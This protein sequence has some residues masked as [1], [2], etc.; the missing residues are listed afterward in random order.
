MRSRWRSGLSLPKAEFIADPKS[1]PNSYLR[2]LRYHHAGCWHGQVEVPPRDPL[3]QGFL[4]DTRAK[5][6]Q[7]VGVP[8]NKKIP[9]LNPR[10]L[11]CS[12]LLWQNM[13]WQHHR[14]ALANPSH[15]IIYIFD[16]D[17]CPDESSASY[18]VRRD[19]PSTYLLPRSQ[20]LIY[21]SCTLVKQSQNPDMFYLTTRLHCRRHGLRMPDSSAFLQG[22][23]KVESMPIPVEHL[24]PPYR[25][26]NQKIGTASKKG[27]TVIV[28]PAKIT[29]PE[30]K[31]IVKEFDGLLVKCTPTD[32]RITAAK[33]LGLKVWCC[34]AVFS[35]VST[36]TL[37]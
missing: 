5:T 16:R 2:Q 30:Q 32:E 14:K 4:F 9:S 25:P 8:A 12:L 22:L 36:C 28:P 17:R 3:G 6:S 31:K 35:R 13:I 15:N 27:V 21:N 19:D 37:T 18:L 7:R 20:T 33:S 11:I 34:K 29:R 1:L 23:N 10:D 24:A 26:N